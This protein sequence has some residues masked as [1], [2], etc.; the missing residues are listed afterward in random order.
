MVLICLCCLFCFVRSF[1]AIWFAL[2][3]VFVSIFES[4]VSLS[5]FLSFLQSFSDIV[6]PATDHLLDPFSMFSFEWYVLQGCTLFPVFVSSCFAKTSIGK[7]RSVQARP[8]GDDKLPRGGRSCACCEWKWPTSNKIQCMWQNHVC[9][10]IIYVFFCF[11]LYITFWPLNINYITTL[12]S[13]QFCS[14]KKKELVQ[15]AAWAQTSH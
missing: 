10:C 4:F 14:N 1:T 8:R 2:W 3:Y 11:C 13:F 12:E 5:F 6:S 7:W 9:C 15:Y